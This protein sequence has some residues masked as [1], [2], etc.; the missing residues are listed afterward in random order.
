EL[1]GSSVF[2]RSLVQPLIID[3][4]DGDDVAVP[5]GIG[6]IAR[7]LASHPDARE[8]N[9]LV[10][11]LAVVRRRRAGNPEAG[12]SKGSGLEKVAT[13]LRKSACVFRF[14]GVFTA[15]GVRKWAS[16]VRRGRAWDRSRTGIRIPEPPPQFHG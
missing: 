8:V 1:L 16:S 4:A 13:V 14:H 7:A 11:R 5:G 10:G 9:S 2:L 6:R 12:T 3:V 15:S